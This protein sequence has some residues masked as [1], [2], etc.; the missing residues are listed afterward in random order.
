M[1]NHSSYSIDDAFEHLRWNIFVSNISNALKSA[2]HILPELM[3]QAQ[4][5][6]EIINWNDVFFRYLV[7]FHLILYCIAAAI[8]VLWKTHEV[9]VLGFSMLLVC[10]S[11]IVFFFLDWLHQH[12]SLFFE[13]NANYFDE[14]GVFVAVV[15]WL[16]IIFCSATL[17]CFVCN[18]V[19]KLYR[20]VRNASQKKKQ[21]S[22]GISS[23]VVR[24]EELYSSSKETSE[25]SDRMK[26]R[27]AD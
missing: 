7:T 27:K 25:S 24:G 18:R 21:R 12:P 10:I 8:W 16:P 23:P 14:A 1:K 13:N 11:S 19:R 6:H 5:A 2:P 4:S 3:H 22:I 20:D 9:V 15:F 17:Q 26:K